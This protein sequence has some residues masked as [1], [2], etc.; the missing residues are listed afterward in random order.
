VRL[1]SWAPDL[2]EYGHGE[3]VTARNCYA[4]SAGYAP[5]KSLSSVTAA[6]TEAWTGAGAFTA[7]DGTK[8]LLSGTAAALYTLTSTVAT[9][10]T[11]GT[12]SKPWYFGQFGNFV[13]CVSGGAPK[14]Y[15]IT[16]D[17]IAALGGSPPNASM[18]AIVK[19][20]VFLAG[21]STAGAT[22][23]W[24][25]LNDCEGWTIGTNQC[26]NQQIPDG[27]LIT[28]L[29]GGEY[30]LV[31]QAAAIHIF[32]YVGTPLIYTRRKISDGIGALCQGVIAQSGKRVFF[33]DR[34]GF[35]QFLDGQITPIG[36]QVT[37]NGVLELVDSTF[38][39][40]YSVAQIEAQC[41]A[42]VDPARQLVVW[43]MPDR[44]WVYNWGNGKWSDIYVPGIV[45]VA[46]GQTGA[47][48]LEDIAV[49]YPSI[50]NVPVSFDD[51]L[52]RGGDPMI[53]VA[54]NDFTLASFG[55]SSNLEA[56]F[57]LPKMQMF[58]GVDACVN[59]A[60][61]DTDATGGVTL[62]I[63]TSRTL[64]GT[65][66]STSSTDLRGNGDMPIRCRGRYVQPQITIAGGSDWSF[67]EGFDL[68]GAS[69]GSL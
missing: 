38:F 42:T 34:S 60:R 52:W 63:D 49:L 12:F 13:V 8:V 61:I 58:K 4:T 32:E 37:Q 22:V 45:G 26:D 54:L 69:G 65:Q 29:T 9:S 59:N 36:R 17:A 39:N 40:T 7:Y 20:Q 33:L 41:H 5:V 3:L 28:G 68:V 19:D 53:L 51:P 11:T 30:G 27:G 64:S 16:T 48:T 46:Q 31:F 15:T 56:Q 6:M 10:K 57:R 18:V 43:S 14:K 62:Q 47:V 50:E 23:T 2:P 21:D 35:Y 66:I 44:L 25:G 24:S 67:V 1:G 55:G